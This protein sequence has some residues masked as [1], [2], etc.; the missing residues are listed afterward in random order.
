MGKAPAFQFYVRDWLSDPS[1]RQIE[2]SSKGIWMDLLCYLW[3]SETRGELTS[4]K[5]GFCRMI[6]CAENEF[7]QFLSDAEKTLF[8]DI[9][10][11]NNVIVTVRNRRMYRDEKQRKNNRERQQKFRENTKGNK[12]IT[13]PSSSSSSTSI[14]KTIDHLHDRFKDF[15]E[16]YPKKT[17]K[18][19]CHTKWKTRKLNLIA[20]K[21]I[22]D[23][24]WRIANDKQWVDGFIPNPLT[25]INQDRWDDDHVGQ[26]EYER[27][28]ILTPEMKE[29]MEKIERGDI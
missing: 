19:P 17:G 6:G 3:E 25:Y 5:R 8:C 10:V 29:H 4:D 14:N 12:K 9:S 28:F 16:I 7:E 21:I 23:V 13:L 22:N 1:L 24:K 20:D 27:P 15:W 18:K 2:F 11:T 26:A